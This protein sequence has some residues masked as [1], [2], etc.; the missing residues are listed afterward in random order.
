MIGGAYPNVYAF[1]GRIGREGEYVMP[2]IR[3]DRLLASTAVALL[4]A[5]SAGGV[6]ADPA[7]ATGDKP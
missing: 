3:V 5:A 1:S 2:G 6:L 7:T 4:L